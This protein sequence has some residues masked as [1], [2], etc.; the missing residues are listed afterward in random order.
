MRD[1]NQTV[2]KLFKMAMIVGFLSMIGSAAMAATNAGNAAALSEAAARATTEFTA[3][4]AEFQTGVRTR[5][6]SDNDLLID[7]S[8]MDRTAEEDT[9]LAASAVR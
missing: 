5:I 4:N 7:D 1:L 9:L 8:Q 6:I 2:T 3:M